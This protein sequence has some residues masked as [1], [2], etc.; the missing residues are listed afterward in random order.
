[1]KHKLVNIIKFLFIKT[2]ININK[3]TGETNAKI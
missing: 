3:L 1:M 2:I